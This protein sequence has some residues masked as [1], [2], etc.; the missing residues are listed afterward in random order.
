MEAGDPTDMKDGTRAIAPLD[1]ST[2]SLACL[3]RSPTRARTASSSSRVSSSSW[4][5]RPLSSST[6]FHVELFPA[7]RVGYLQG[8]PPGLAESE[9]EI[10]VGGGSSCIRSGAGTRHASFEQ[11]CGQFAV[12][13]AGK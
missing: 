7:N 13:T 8:L 4:L 12:G 3:A 10:S 9:A 6:L 5:T 11:C 2:L 1:V